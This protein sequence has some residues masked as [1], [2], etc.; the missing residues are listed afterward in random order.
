MDLY[1]EKYDFGCLSP[2]KMELF[3]KLSSLLNNV[4]KESKKR[5]SSIKDISI[6]YQYRPTEL[7]E[8]EEVRIY[9]SF[10][11]VSGVI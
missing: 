5:N 11:G 10:S 6:V 9:A 4:I 8:G 7:D 2:S 1:E 3:T